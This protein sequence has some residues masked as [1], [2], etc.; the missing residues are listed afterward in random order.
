M[1]K[2]ILFVVLLGLWPLVLRADEVGAAAAEK[3]AL[4][5]FA[6]AEKSDSPLRW[7]ARAEQQAGLWGNPYQQAHSLAEIAKPP[8]PRRLTGGHEALAL[9]ALAGGLT[10]LC[11]YPMTP[12][13]S[14]FNALSQ[15]ASAGE[16]W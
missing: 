1:R 13:T 12:W 3:M 9:G 11:G 8:E 10:F 2:L 14:L 6:G 16:W 7:L 4:G 5:R 15:R